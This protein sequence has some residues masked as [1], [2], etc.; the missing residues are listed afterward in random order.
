MSFYFP[1][2]K[3]CAICSRRVHSSSTSSSKIIDSFNDH[4]ACRAN[5]QQHGYRTL[6]ACSEEWHILCSWQCF[7]LHLLVQVSRSDDILLSTWVINSAYNWVPIRKKIY[8]QLLDAGFVQL[9]EISTTRNTLVAMTFKC[10][11]LQEICYCNES[12]YNADLD[13]DD[14]SSIKY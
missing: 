14:S 2:R 8:F 4:G 9:T 11:K 5:T 10:E 12:I 3:P 6:F 1:A 13:A 7:K